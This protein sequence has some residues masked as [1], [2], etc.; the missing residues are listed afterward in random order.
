M[1][2]F[3]FTNRSTST[4]M[5]FQKHYIAHMRENMRYWFFSESFFFYY[6]N[7]FPSVLLQVHYFVFFMS[8]YTPLCISIAFKNE[9]S[10]DGH[11]GSFYSLGFVTSAA[12][13]FG[14]DVSLF[15]V[16]LD[17]FG[18]IPRSG[19]YGRSTFSFSKELHI[20]V[21]SDWTNLHSSSQQE[22]FQPRVLS[23]SLFVLCFMVS[24]WMGWGGFS[25]LVFILYFAGG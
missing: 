17:S 21:H 8:K 14:I 25:A 16:N 22:F 23:W 3:N 5:S 7:S 12:V 11:I 13:N 2:P 15:H 9:S 4:Y 20:T 24:I 18:S 6:D 19:T 1:V 10:I